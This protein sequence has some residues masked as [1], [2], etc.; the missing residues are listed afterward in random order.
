MKK[1]VQIVSKIIIV[2]LLILTLVFAYLSIFHKDLL[3]H[4][5][6]VFKWLI[7]NLW[8]WN[9]LIIFVFW[10]IE[11]FPLLWVAVPGQLVLIIIAWFLGF[12]HIYLTMACASLWA[13]LWNYVWYK[14]W[15]HYG[16]SFFDKYWA[17]IGVM[18]TDIKYIK[19]WIDSHGWLFVVLW[20]FHNMFRAFVP[21]IA[22]SSKMH[23][24]KFALANIFGS[25]L[26]WVVMV[27]LWVFFVENAEVILENIGK[28]I[29]W[30]LVVFMAYI[31]FFQKE[32]FMIYWKE[33]NEEMEKMLNKS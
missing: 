18:K 4:Y 28:I 33:K 32:K 7:S 17:W 6:D 13:I 23:S 30:I 12:D 1:F 8:Y 16:E 31:Y 15:I 29:L 19:K 21:F 24:T 9:Y 2:L 11:S 27:L 20:K 14:M 25:I 5:L 10:F 3:L 26:R 22:G